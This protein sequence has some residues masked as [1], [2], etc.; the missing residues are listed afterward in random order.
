MSKFTRYPD[1]YVIRHGQTEWNVQGRHQGR[2]DSPLTEV[3]RAQAAQMGRTL[4]RELEAPEKLNIFSSPQGRARDTARI[5]LSVLGGESVPD[6]RLC[7]VHFGAWQGKTDTEIRAGWPALA[8]MADEDPIGWNFLSPGGET[9]ADLERRVDGFLN[10]L[11]GPSIVFT[12]GVLSRVL[13]ARWLGLNPYEMA[14][15][16]GGQGEIFHL[17]QQ[18]GHVVVEK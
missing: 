7:E 6:A 9:L 18:L 14:G 11:S 5:A 4:L 3:G 17:S 10:D 13:R 8:A 1:L 15:L 12:H 2:L 16:A